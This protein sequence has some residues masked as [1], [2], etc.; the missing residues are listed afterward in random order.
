MAPISETTAIPPGV[1]GEFIRGRP[2]M[3]VHLAKREAGVPDLK[4]NDAVTEMTE[5]VHH[6]ANCAPRHVH[7]HQGSN[8]KDHRGAQ[9]DLVGNPFGR[10]DGKDEVGHNRRPEIGELYRKNG[11]N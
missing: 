1:P 7:Y 5:P 2:T 3:D 6:L 8:R 9:K 4:K 11:K 10:A